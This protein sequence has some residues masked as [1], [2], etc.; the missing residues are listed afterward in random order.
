MKFKIDKMQDALKSIQ[1]ICNKQSSFAIL[2]CCLIQCHDKQVDIVATDLQVQMKIQLKTD[3]E[4]SVEV[5]EEG[6]VLVKAKNLL[7]IVSKLPKNATMTFETND[8]K[9]KLSYETFKSNIPTCD[10]NEFPEIAFGDNKRV[11]KVGAG[12]FKDALSIVQKSASSDESRPEFTGIYFD[13]KDSKIT[14][15]STDGHRMTMFKTNAELGCADTKPF[16]IPQ[17]GTTS[18]IRMIGNKSDEDLSIGFDKKD[19]LVVEC[20]DTILS[21]I[22]ISGQFPDFSNVIPTTFETDATVK[23]KEILESMS[24]I[25]AFE[26]DHNV[27][28]FN[29]DDKSIELFTSSN[30]KGE[31]SMSVSACND[32]KG[33]IFGMNGEYFRDV[34]NC[35][36]DDEIRLMLVDADSPILVKGTDTDAFQYVIMPM[37]L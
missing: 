9:L 21:V 25:G 4:R 30:T 2:G 34:L 18:I 7:E 36:K 26:G 29:I 8:D 27:V 3:N 5:K 17:I 13:I 33:I 35:V 12:Q 22:G 20:G 28:R 23:T 1:P 37:Q 6:K 19:R 14:L 16:I 32:G 31:A 11:T 24:I 15:C 10:L